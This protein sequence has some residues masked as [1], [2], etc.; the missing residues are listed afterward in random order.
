MMATADVRTAPVLAP[1]LPSAR[2]VPRING[3]DAVR[4]L[5]ALSVALGHAWY[6][7]GMAH[8]DDG[9]LHDLV[10][11]SYLG[12][13]VFFVISGMVLLHPVAR[14]AGI[15]RKR[16]FY[17]RR[18]ARIAPLYLLCLMVALLARSALYV[19]E[20]AVGPRHEITPGL[21][22]AH[23]TFT[24]NAFYGGDS[25]AVGFG[26]DGVIWTLAVEATFYLV[27][28]LVAVWWLRHPW[29]GLGL[30]L[31]LSRAWVFVGLHLDQ[32]AGTFGVTFDKTGLFEARMRWLAEAPTY[33]GHFAVG[34][35]LAVVLVR[36]R[37]GRVVGA[38]QR[39]AGLVALLGAAEVLGFML[40]AGHRGWAGQLLEFD[41]LTTGW[42]ALPGIALL[43]LGVSLR[44][45]RVLDGRVGRFVGD[46]S[47]A[48]Y[49]L[50]LMVIEWLVLH[51]HVGAPGS[52]SRLLVLLAGVACTYPAAAITYRFV[53]VPLRRRING[54][55]SRRAA[56]APGGDT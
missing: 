41:H 30:A 14:G 6:V 8:L 54:D 19:P 36:H 56:A 9:L 1:D 53:E 52:S 27:L 11:T 5:A 34:M 2:L 51:V 15:G 40:W 37:E 21:L 23:L 42:R 25:T 4:G 7:G 35:T 31:G 49:L 13:D 12:V 45:G 17:R 44:T 28:P 47:Y 10:A 39:R 48:L 38:L 16:D 24:H 18:W 55:L 33:A 20:M 29:L 46:T 26:V 32:M 43:L 50:H 22:L 3:V